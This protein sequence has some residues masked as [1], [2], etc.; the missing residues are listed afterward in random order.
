MYNVATLPVLSI[1]YSEASVAK[2]VFCTVLSPIYCVCLVSLIFFF[3]VLFTSVESRHDLQLRFN[4]LNP[5]FDV[6]SAEIAP[7]GDVVLTE[8]QVRSF[9]VF[10]GRILYKYLLFGSHLYVIFFS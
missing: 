3:L 4:E 2:F 9:K 6:T 5:N 8:E 7:D 10:T 1:T